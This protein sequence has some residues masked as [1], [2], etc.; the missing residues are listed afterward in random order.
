VKI[1]DLSRPYHQ[2]EI[3]LIRK[4]IDRCG[5]PI[6]LSTSPGETPIE[7]AG[8]GKEWNDRKTDQCFYQKLIFSIKK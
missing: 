3:E 6:A 8:H 2:D 5:R 7:S 4:A 1:D